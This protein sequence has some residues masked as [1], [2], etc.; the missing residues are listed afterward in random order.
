MWDFN[1]QGSLIEKN[2]H[3]ILTFDR[4]GIEMVGV[5]H[6]SRPINVHYFNLYAHSRDAPAVNVFSQSTFSCSCCHFILNPTPRVL[7]TG[8]EPIFHREGDEIVV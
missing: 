3:M 1:L 5:F 2:M 4:C 8:T 7:G 6:V